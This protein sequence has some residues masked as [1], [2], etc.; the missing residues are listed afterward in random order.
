M[1]CSET[2]SG[3]RGLQ[4]EL[5]TG[6]PV[7]SADS[8]GPQHRFRPLSQSLSTQFRPPAPPITPDERYTILETQNAKLREEVESLTMMVE[9]LR[10]DAERSRIRR[11]CS[12]SRRKSVSRLQSPSAASKSSPSPATLS[13]LDLSADAEIGGGQANSTLAVP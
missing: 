11:S 4:S 6:T 12:G 3:L 8:E 2:F 1:A 5:A 7:Q 10:G 13:T 9:G